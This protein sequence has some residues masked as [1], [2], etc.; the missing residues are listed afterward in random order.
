MARGVKFEPT[1]GQ[2]R[3]LAENYPRTKNAALAAALGVSETMLHRLARR[4]G[5]RKDAEF[6]RRCQAEAAQA[7]VADGLATGRFRRLSERMKGRVSAAFEARMFRAGNRPPRVP[8]ESRARAA[9]KRRETFKAERRRLLFGLPQRTRLRV[10]AQSRG[11]VCY[12]Y[13]MRRLGYVELPG[14]KN[15]LR[16]PDEGMRRPAAEKGAAGHGIRILPLGGQ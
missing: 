16:Y 13:C 15:M 4:L 8:P 9:E 7:A 6:M 12:R 5:A 14:E 10:T 2:L 3:W 11:K 1:E